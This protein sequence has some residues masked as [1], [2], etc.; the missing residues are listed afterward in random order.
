MKYLTNTWPEAVAF[1]ESV[2]GLHDAIIEEVQVLPIVNVCTL[3]LS[4]VCQHSV[5]SG[6]SVAYERLHV[7]MVEASGPTA[8]LADRCVGYDIADAELLQ[9]ELWVKT[10]AG[11]IS[12]QFRIIR[13]VEP[14]SEP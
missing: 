1:F 6:F 7:E 11:S 5:K 12:F 3:V 8:E 2:V 9:G 4:D 10:L 13:F 14:E